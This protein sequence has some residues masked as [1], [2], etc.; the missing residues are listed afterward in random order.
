MKI[1]TFYA[2]DNKKLDK[3]VNDFLNSSRI[4]VIDFKFSHN[5]FYFSVMVI[6]NEN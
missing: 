2:M 6:F 1:K 3:K 5:I 4:E